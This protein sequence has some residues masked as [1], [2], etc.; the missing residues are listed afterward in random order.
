MDDGIQKILMDRIAELTDKVVEAEQ[1]TVAAWKEVGDAMR[2]GRPNEGLAIVYGKLNKLIGRN[3]ELAGALAM[4]FT[5]LVFSQK[6]PSV[7]GHAPE[8]P[9]QEV[10]DIIEAMSGDASADKIKATLDA[11]TK[12]CTDAKC[13]IQPALEEKLRAAS[14]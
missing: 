2:A 11:H 13:A 10:D 4:S 7:P 12:W 14:H 9:Q 3:E 5:F 8:N 1:R 6:A